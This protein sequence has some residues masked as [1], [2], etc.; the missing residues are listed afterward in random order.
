MNEV[1]KK[2]HKDEEAKAK[3]AKKD[4]DRKDK[5]TPPTLQQRLLEFLRVV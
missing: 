4:G 1:M 5:M 3:E 2:I